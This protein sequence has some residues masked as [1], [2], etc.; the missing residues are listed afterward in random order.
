MDLYSKPTDSKRYVPF[1]SC[2]PKPCLTNIPYC[3]ARR[4][5]MIV[6]F[7]QEKENKLKELKLILQ[8]QG[9]EAVLTYVHWILRHKCLRLAIFLKIL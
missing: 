7:F 8:K 9:Y 1:D 6:E 3:L 4:I 5:C 2:Y